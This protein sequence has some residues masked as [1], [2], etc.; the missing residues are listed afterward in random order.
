MSMLPQSLQYGLERYLAIRERSVFEVRSYLERK[1]KEKHI[2]L[3]P[4]ELDAAIA[5]YKELNLMDDERFAASLVR[6]MLARKKGQ[7]F[8][9]MELKKAGVDKAIITEAMASLDADDVQI[10]MAKR[11]SRARTKLAALSGNERRYKA[12][13]ILAQGG[14]SGSDLMRFIDDWLEKEYNEPTL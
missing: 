10:A 12:R 2:P 1:A 3:V 5:R 13:A 4:E 14:F 7:Q 9:S 6:R 8:I 11:L